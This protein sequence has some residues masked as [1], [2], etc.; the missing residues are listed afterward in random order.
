MSEIIITDTIEEVHLTINEVQGNDGKSAYEI[1]L[2]HGFVGTEQEWLDY[3]KADGRS[4]EF[5]VVNSDSVTVVHSLGYIPLI[6]IY[7]SEGHY[8][9]ASV[10]NTSPNQFSVFFDTNFNGKIIYK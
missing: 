7:N 6:S 5:Q 2:L 1:A 9:F 10:L 4:Y 8:V 3:L